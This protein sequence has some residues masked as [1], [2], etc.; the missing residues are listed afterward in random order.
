MIIDKLENVKQYSFKY[1]G[2]YKAFEFLRHTDLINLGEGKHDIDNDDLFALVNTS[3][4]TEIAGRYPEA[5]KKYIDV[6]YIVSGEEL[7]GYAPYNNQKIQKE[8]FEARDIF[9]CFAETTFVKL[10]QGMFAIVFPGD[11]HLPVI[12]FKEVSPV[13]KIVIKVKI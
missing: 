3:N 6:Q 5:H 9:F 10:E 2:I 11:L 1:E 7:F 8:Y 12:K 13:K 4:T